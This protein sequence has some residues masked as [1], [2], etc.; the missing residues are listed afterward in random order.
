M[1]IHGEGVERATAGHRTAVN[2][3]GLEVDEI[4]RGEVLVQ[5]GTFVPTTLADV[6]VNLLAGEKALKDRTRVRVHA[7]SAEVLGRLELVG[8]PTLPPGAPVPARLRLEAP[9]VLGRGDRLV[10]RSYSPALTIGGARVLDPL[11]PR[12]RRNDPSV[13]ARLLA[14]AAADLVGAVRLFVE[15]AGPRGIDLARLAARVTVPRPRLATL[16]ADEAGLLVVGREPGTA[17]ARLTLERQAAAVLEALALYHREQRLRESMPLEEL[18]ARLFAS[19]PEG[20]A[21][22]VL[23]GL[24][25]EGLVRL[26]AEGVALATHQT[27]LT[28]REEQVR[29]ALSEAARVAGLAGLTPDDVARAAGG[30]A[31]LGEQ[32]TRAL[33][34]SGQLVRVGT[35][36]WVSREHVEGLVQKVRQ[37]W[38][39]GSAL[40]VGAFKELTGLTRK[41]AIPLL[42]LLDARRVT[43]RVGSERIVSA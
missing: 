20:A 5:P 19:S 4:A 40:D 34:T 21:G 25:A 32:V 37:R 29:A 2:L 3:V 26:S 31:R 6:E 17:V 35:A 18:R 28:P 22:Q 41:H 16:L 23:G 43:R 7:G 1:Q 36:C 27:T 42:E 13:K 15:E 11:A 8:A 10:L 24:E 12:R 30:E 9:V 33:V 38:A 39:P 14:L